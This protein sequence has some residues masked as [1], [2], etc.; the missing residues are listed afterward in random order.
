[1]GTSPAR[2]TRW[3]LPVAAAL[4]VGAGACQREAASTDLRTYVNA[5]EDLP[6]DLR[7]SFVPFSLDYPVDWEIASE[8]R[9][10][11]MF[12]QLRGPAPA[13]ARWGEVVSIYPFH[14]VPEAGLARELEAWAT[15][16]RSIHGFERARE[17]PIEI[18]GRNLPSVLLDGLRGEDGEAVWGRVVLM[19]LQ[20]DPVGGREGLVVELIGHSRVPGIS[21]PDDLGRGAGAASIL[22]SLRGFDPVD[23]GITPEAPERPATSRPD[24]ARPLR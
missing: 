15:A 5:I 3:A 4:L 10:S 2:G 13:G 1:M 17:E 20:S 8:A 12:V 6:P 14:G 24:H 19:P 11:G 22:G 16:I 21:G 18:G 7:E 23:G 9:R